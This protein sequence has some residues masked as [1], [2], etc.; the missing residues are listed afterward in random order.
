MR[1]ASFSVNFSILLS[2]S[3]VFTSKLTCTTLPE[4]RYLIVSSDVVKQQFF[5]VSYAHF[6]QASGF[7][8]EDQEQSAA[9]DAFN[10]LREL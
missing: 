5:V 6:V 8:G 10:I 3:K 4:F 7:V 1:N 9:R 2:S